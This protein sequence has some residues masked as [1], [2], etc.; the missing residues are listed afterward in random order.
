MSDHY[1]YLL[2]STTTNKTYVGYTVNLQRRLRQHNGIIKGGAKYTI[3]G[4]PFEMVCAIKFPNKIIALQYE[5]RNH[6]I[7]K[8]WTRKYGIIERIKNMKKILNMERFT[9]RAIPTNSFNVEIIWFINEYEQYFI[10]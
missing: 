1:V 7:P 6:H 4:R 3:T 9:S 8:N 10:I 2:K 5:W